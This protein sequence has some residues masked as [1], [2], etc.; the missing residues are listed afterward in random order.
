MSAASDSAHVRIMIADYAVV[1]HRGKATMV[2]AG[3]SIIG[4]N[5]ESGMT[6]PFA[7]FASVSFGPEFVGDNPAVE[8]S[9]ENGA[10]QLVTMPGTVGLAGEAQPQYLRVATSNELLPTV[11]PGANIPGD[12][13]RPKSQLLLHFQNGLP[14][15]PGHLY[16]WR[17]KVDGETQD[18]WTE[19]IYVPTASA[20]P[21]LG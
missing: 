1:D 11:L 9:L 3:V 16:R 7:V 20:G 15:A 12:V 10:G 6:A 18:A 21:V 13:A 19:S 4:V 8:L 5:P 17:V 14:L 2:G